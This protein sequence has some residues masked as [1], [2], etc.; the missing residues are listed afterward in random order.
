MD[1][2][3]RDKVGVYRSNDPLRSFKIE[4]TLRKV[5]AG[6][7]FSPVPLPNARANQEGL[8]LNEMRHEN[9]SNTETCVFAWQEKLFSE[10]EEDFYADRNNCLTPLE[11]KY[12][13]DVVAVK[14]SGGR[15]NSRIFTY[16]DHDQYTDT[17]E[18]VATETTS[19]QQVT[20]YLV[21]NVLN[22]RQRRTGARAAFE[23]TGRRDDGQAIT[24][25][26]DPVAIPTSAESVPANHVISTPSQTMHVMTDL[27]PADRL[28][29]LEDEHLLCT[30]RADSH[31][32]IT[33]KP[34]FNQKGKRYYIEN[35]EGELFEFTI[36]H[37]SSPMSRSIKVQETNMFRELYGRH[38]EILLSAVGQDFAR[39][40]SENEILFCAFGE[41][42]S[43]ADFEYDGLY[44]EYFVHLPD[45][46]K[47][48]GLDQKL[49]G[50]S[51]ISYTRQT[52]DRTVAHFGFP[53]EFEVLFNS[54]LLEDGQSP[55][56]PEVYL[57]VISLDFWERHRTEGYGRL[58]LPQRSGVY[59]EN[60]LTWRPFGRGVV[61]EMRRY[62]IGGSPELDDITYVSKPTGFTGSHMS[63]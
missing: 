4:V 49:T 43:A 27:S 26:I 28:G 25:R 21:Q 31:G 11:L 55:H 29:Q 34:D 23:V 50:I 47:P 63:R 48:S 52:G 53:F 24:S 20:S 13:D 37:V 44:V 15:R 61:S 2:T 54:E 62:F 17:T 19:S 46:W 5:A 1:P 38:S 41:I 3:S 32:V 10:R 8:E 7:V 58:V 36:K 16:V 14:A 35:T 51:N 59:Q 56:M 30:L 57:Q 45:G 6:S 42:V 40:H 12:N 22:V 39:P 18:C 60:I 33:V 9:D